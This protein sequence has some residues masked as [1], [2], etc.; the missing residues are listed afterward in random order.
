MRI[1]T[2]THPMLYLPLS[3]PPTPPTPLPPPSSPLSRRALSRLVDSYAYVW[4]C[5]SDTGC[6]YDPSDVAGA[7]AT[8]G[9]FATVVGVERGG[10]EI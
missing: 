4:H 6:G 1:Y 8:P 9:E 2:P 5:L 3:R 10:V 7:E